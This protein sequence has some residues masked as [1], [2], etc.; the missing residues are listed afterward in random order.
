MTRRND[1]RRVIHSAA[2]F[3]SLWHDNEPRRSN[4]MRRPSSD[5][6]QS[7]A[8]TALRVATLGTAFALLL[9]VIL[10]GLAPLSARADDK[11][12]LLDA[13]RT[14][15]AFAIMRHALAPGYSDPAGFDVDDCSTQRNLSEQG[16]S[17]ARA[18][19]EVFRQRGITQANVHSS[20]WCRCLETA[21]LLGL[22]DVTK[23]EPLNSFFEA[24]HRR[25]AQ[26]SALKQWLIAY[27]GAKPLVLVTHQVNIRALTGAATRSGETVI[28]NID[29]A[30][31]ITVL[32][33]IE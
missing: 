19:G 2:A 17:Q 28:A 8:R 24:R 22:G 33:S 26:T 20:A 21:R 3:V 32:G 4:R 31:K 23:L 18:T 7:H 1:A 14:G 29:D 11:D 27:D 10:M 6:T 13:V 9:S 30:G 16:R 25:D 5:P 15:K 12:R